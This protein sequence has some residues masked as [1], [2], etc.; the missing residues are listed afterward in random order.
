MQFKLTR[1][2]RRRLWKAFK[3]NHKSDSAIRDLGCSINKLK[4]HLEAKFKPGMTGSNYSKWY[5]DNIIPLSNFNLTNKQN[6]QKACHYT[7]LQ[8]LWAK[9]NII[10]SN[11]IL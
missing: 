3:N 7:N 6:C 8:P 4:Q 2:L 10:K 5:I 11:D 9:E 1:I